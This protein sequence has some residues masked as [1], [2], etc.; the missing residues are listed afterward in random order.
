MMVRLPAVSRAL[1]SLGD[2]AWLTRRRLLAAA[3]VL[4]LLEA[5]L[6]GIVIAGSHGLFGRGEPTTTDFISFYA[7]GRLADGGTPALVYDRIAH[8]AAERQVANAAIP[9]IYFYYPPTYV[10]VCAVLARLPYLPAFV[11]FQAATLAWAL[12]AM[13]AILHERRWLAVLPL[14]AFAP[15]FWTMGLGQNAFL[16]AALFATATLSLGRRPVLAGLLFGAICYKPHFGLLLPIALAAGG[17]WRAFAAAGAAALG[18]CALSLALFGWETW[19]AYV[20]A[21]AGSHAVYASGTLDLA[22]YISPFGAARSLGLPPAA[23]GVVQ[24]AATLIAASAVRTTWRRRLSLP[25]RAAILAAATPVAVPV[26]LVYD[27]VL[28]GIAMAWLVRWGHDHGFLP[29]QRLALAVLFVWPLLGLNMDPATYLLAPPAVAIG[30]FV[31][32]WLCARRE[33]TLPQIRNVLPTVAPE[34]VTVSLWR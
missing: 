9:Y 19:H 6:L 18:L 12:A 22:A 33:S 21:F 25:V 14:I 26:G 29:W 34:A 20:A 15:A 3:T 2:G 8:G 13:R 10:L 32:A 17:H 1:H 24:S 27:L 28:S 31:L 5:A 23:S 4:L 7:A 16:T 30:V 11:A